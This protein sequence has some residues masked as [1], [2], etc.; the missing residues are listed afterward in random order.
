MR[1]TARGAI[2][3]GAVASAALASAGAAA[4][5]TVTVAGIGAVEVPAL[6]QPVLDQL[7]T[8]QAQGLI[9]QAPP[10]VKQTVDQLLPQIAPKSV[11][12]RALD[13]ARTRVGTPYIWG[14]QNPG[15]FDCS[16]LVK[17]SYSQAGVRLP[18]TSQQQARFGKPV[19]PSD[20]KPGDVVIYN[21][22]T[23]AA[24]Y[25]GDGNILQAPHSG[26]RVRYSP[27]NSMGKITAVRRA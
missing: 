16:G 26:D 6:P 18:R 23:H 8:P 21:G 4:A 15:G 3:A 12:E 17:W 11:G 2:I 19:A 24:L 1:V 14:G 5:Q 22:G 10:Q 13:A 9:S 7:S 20:L 25:A 27:L